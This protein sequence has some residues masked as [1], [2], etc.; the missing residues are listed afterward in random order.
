MRFYGYM[1]AFD[2]LMGVTVG[3][4]KK[5]TYMALI[6]VVLEM[7]VDAFVGYSFRCS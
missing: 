6:N 4:E 3:I 1:C 7:V 2:G 5:S